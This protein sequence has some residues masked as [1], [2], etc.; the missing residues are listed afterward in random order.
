MHDLESHIM[1][2]RDDPQ[3]MAI[4]YL[5]FRGGHKANASERMRPYRERV[6]EFY[7]LP[8]E[9]DGREPEVRAW[10]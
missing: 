4:Y 3:H 9:D 6:R 5:T 8:E 7:W 1:S 2:Q 10:G